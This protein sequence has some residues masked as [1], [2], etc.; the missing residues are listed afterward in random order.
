MCAP[1]SVKNC[2]ACAAADQ[3]K[4]Q[5]VELDDFS[6]AGFG[7]FYDKSFVI[8]FHSPLGKDCFAGTTSNKRELEIIQFA[9]LHFCDL[10]QGLLD[11]RDLFLCAFHLSVSFFVTLVQ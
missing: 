8:H 3:S 5:L 10:S 1:I 6:L 7:N 2:L 4:L 9:N 11:C